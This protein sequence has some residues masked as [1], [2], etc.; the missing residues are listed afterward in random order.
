MLTKIYTK[1]LLNCSIICKLTYKVCKIKFVRV[2]RNTI[3]NKKNIAYDTNNISRDGKTFC[4]KN[5]ETNLEIYLHEK[6]KSKQVV[7]PV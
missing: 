2:K 7:N 3:F 1:N 5:V 4:E 6:R